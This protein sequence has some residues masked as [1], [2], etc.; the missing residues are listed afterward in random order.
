[1]SR[2]DSN[3]FRFDEEVFARQIG[4]LP[5]P[6]C[7]DLLD[8]AM[9]IY[10][11]DRLTRRNR[12]IDVDGPSRVLPISTVPVS[13]PEFWMELKPQVQYAI[14][15]LTGDSWD[16]RFVSREP[17]EC[18]QVLW[19]SEPTDEAIVCLQSDGLDSVAGLANRLLESDRPV[20]A[21]TA[22]HNIGIKRLV[23]DQ[24]LPLL[25]ERFGN[26]IR[27]L[28]VPATLRHPPPMSQQ[29]VTQR[30][31]SFLFAAL[32]GVAAAEL[33]ANEVEVYENGVGVVNLPPMTGM[34]LGGRATRS[35]HPEF[36]RRMEA[37]L[38]EVIG[39][40]IT[41]SL[42]FRNRTKAEMVA[43][44]SGDHKLEEAARQSA[45]CIHYPR[46]VKGNA[47]HCGLCPGCIGRR[48][49]MISAGI[50]ETCDRYE[51]DFL[52]DANVDKCDVEQLD[53]LKAIVTQVEFLSCV[54]S[55]D[56]LPLSVRAHL[57]KVLCSRES[58]ERTI[59]LL[60]RY[61]SE[62]HH[63]IETGLKHSRRWAKW[64]G[65]VAKNKV[66]A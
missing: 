1:M 26:R 52:S 32:G 48:Q 16:F 50:D 41:F 65:P 64:H 60:Q 45:S 57:A 55:S 25:R 3:C 22:L 20:F 24:Q 56:S 51:I 58:P 47:K 9:H 37:L 11:G 12:R 33:G 49:A 8:L 42:P 6:K 5:G 44:L 4:R 10:A 34:Q 29:E 28:M 7:R 54:T 63:L 19:D 31:R 36:F 66:A 62:W 30:G 61:R 17:R 15:F 27:S 43:T 38:Q 35:A 2:R 53:H 13:D 40:P 14:D 21:V 23:R 39:R 59:Q 18:Q 46:R